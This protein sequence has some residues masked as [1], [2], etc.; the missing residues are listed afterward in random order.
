MTFKTLLAFVAASFTPALAPITRLQLQGSESQ[1]CLEICSKS[2]F[3]KSY[4]WRWPNLIERPENGAPYADKSIQHTDEVITLGSQQ[5]ALVGSLWHF[6]WW[7]TGLG[8][9]YAPW[10]VGFT[11]SLRHSACRFGPV[12]RHSTY[13]TG[14][15]HWDTLNV[16]YATVYRDRCELV[17][18]DTLLP[19][20]SFFFFAF[21]RIVHQITHEE[22]CY[23]HLCL[24]N[25]LLISISFSSSI[26]FWET[27]HKVNCF[28]RFL[29]M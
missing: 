5:V 3:K 15:V 4:L 1:L 10:Q 16:I 8:H 6:A 20:I 25:V 14:L 21:L 27:F 28:L 9:R 19:F 22:P 23:H 17:Y 26:S 7:R 18:L 2:F 12:Q 11:G 13:R 24:W 29:G